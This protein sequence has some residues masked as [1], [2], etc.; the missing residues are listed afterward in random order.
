MT[1]VRS[2]QHRCHI[3]AT[4][5]P[6]PAGN[7]GGASPGPFRRRAT[8]HPSSLHGMPRGPGGATAPDPG[9]SLV[10][11]LSQPS[12]P[13]PGSPDPV[14]DFFPVGDLTANMVVNPPTGK[15]SPR[16]FSHHPGANRS[17]PKE[18][19]N[20]ALHPAHHGGRRDHEN[21]PGLPVVTPA[22]QR[23]PRPGNVRYGLGRRGMSLSRSGPGWWG[24]GWAGLGLDFW[25]STSCGL[26][27]RTR[28]RRGCRRR[29]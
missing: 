8:H 20:P 16:S 5:G 14:G 7:H 21:L 9:W 1:G 24:P 13:L 27:R 29:P 17:T 28:R 3:D 10:T 23:R 6:A 19:P 4:A 25:V 22:S 26:A 18:P 12:H 15:K 2:Q 11:Q